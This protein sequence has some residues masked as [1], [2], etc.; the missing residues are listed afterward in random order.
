MREKGN[1]HSVLFIIRHV[2]IIN[3]IPKTLPMKADFFL[4]TIIA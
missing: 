3:L 1:F 4:V 2:E